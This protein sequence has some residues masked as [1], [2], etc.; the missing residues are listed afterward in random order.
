[1]S[2]IRLGI[3]PL[4]NTIFAGKL[5]KAETMW[6]SG[7]QNVTDDA[8]ML[9]VDYIKKDNVIYERDGKRFQLKEIEIEAN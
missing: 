2:K 5:N 7:K 6:L 9:V 4:T 3:S 8:V 1:M